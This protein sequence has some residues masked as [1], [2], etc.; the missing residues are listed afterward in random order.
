MDKI[1]LWFMEISVD[2]LMYVCIVVV[3]KVLNIRYL[4]IEKNLLIVCCMVCY[5]FWFNVIFVCVCFLLWWWCVC[6][7]WVFFVSVLLFVRIWKLV[8]VF[9]EGLLVSVRFV[10]GMVIFLLVVLY[11]KKCFL[12][13]VFL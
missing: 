7:L 2:V 1:G 4:F 9:L 13:L 11:F 3:I 12:S 10:V 6:F 8:V 5:I